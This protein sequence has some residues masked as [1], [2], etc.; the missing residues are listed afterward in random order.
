[1][2]KYEFYPLGLEHEL[3]KQQD[4]LTLYQCRLASLL[5][6]DMKDSNLEKHF[7]DKI[8]DATTNIHFLEIMAA[9]EASLAA[10]DR[11]GLGGRL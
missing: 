1:M 10:V 5:S 4:R 3:R 11:L 2:I 8:E 7:R 9:W 6:Q